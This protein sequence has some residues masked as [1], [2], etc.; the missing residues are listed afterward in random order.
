MGA[1]ALEPSHRVVFRAFQIANGVA[2]SGEIN[3][4]G[5]MLKGF[6]TPAAMDGTAFS[7]QAAEKEGG[8]FRDVYDDAGAE[9][10]VTMAASRYVT[11]TGADA[12]SMSGLDVIKVRTGLTGAP[13]NQTALRT[14]T[15]VLAMSTK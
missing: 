8:T 3:L 4:R 13:T 14:I 15:L 6:I 2:I 1:V 12:E 9:V 11:I 10:S 7:F 5:Y